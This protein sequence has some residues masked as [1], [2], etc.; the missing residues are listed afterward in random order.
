[1]ENIYAIRMSSLH[2]AHFLKNL[3]VPQ[4]DECKITPFWSFVY[5]IFLKIVIYE[6]RLKKK[7]YQ[8]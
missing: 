2:V 8:R 1:M 5:I 6:D 3:N 4:K 7:K